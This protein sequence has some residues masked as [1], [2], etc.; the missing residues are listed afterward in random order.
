MIEA[1]ASGLK[2]AV[3]TAAAP[4]AVA[5]VGDLHN[6]Y[7]HGAAGNRQLLPEPLPAT[8]DTV[9]DLASLTKVVATTTAIMQCRD[10]GIIDLDDSVGGHLA[11]PAFNALTIRQLLTHTSG[12][13]PG[14]PFY[15][16]ATSMDEMLGMYAS[17]N[18]DRTPG[19]GRT[20]SDVGFMML[21][22][23]V[24]LATWNRLDEFCRKYIFD[25]LEMTST[26]FNP[27]PELALRAA[28]TENCTWRGRIMCGEVHDENAYA[29]GG[30]S[31]HAGLFSTAADLALFC[32]GLLDGSLF[33]ESTVDEMMQLGLL[34]WYPWQGLGWQ[35]DPWLNTSSGFLPSRGAFGHTGWTGTCL[36][37]DREINLIA[38]LLSNTCHPTRAGRHNA[39]LRETFYT[40]VAKVFYPR[41]ANTHLGIDRLV[42]DGFDE[43]AGKRIA[44]LTNHAAVDSLG[45]H[46]TDVL[47]LAPATRIARLYSPEH[48]IAG[49]AEAGEKVGS[50]SAAAP[51]TSLYGQQ[52]R[53]TQNELN[54]IDVFVIDLP[55]VG[56]RYYTYAATMK[57][58]LAACAEAGVRVLVL[59]RPNPLGG[60]VLEGP[61]AGQAGSPVCWGEVPVRH[62]M[63]MGEIARWFQAAAFAKSKLKL[64]ISA[65]DNW[66]RGNLYTECSLPWVPPSP[67]IPTPET[68]LLYVGMCLFEGTNLNEGRGTEIPFHVVGAPW[69]DARAVVGAIAAEDCPGCQLSPVQYTPVSIPGKAAN[70]RFQNQTCQGVR[71]DIKA[72]H[73]LR[74]FRTAVAL[75]NA[76]RHLHKSDFAWADSF[77]VLAGGPGLRQRIEAGT[78]AKD[79]VAGFESALT[80]YDKGRPKL[81]E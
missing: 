13:V 9:Y 80:A 71:I 52:K 44:V 51:V 38:I 33:K 79:I 45:R 69:L 17:M 5:Y 28:A 75:L 41:H 16:E 50:Q 19:T 54:T 22:R 2:N 4:G 8:T 81:Y 27:P 61:V 73:D 6:T 39:V 34:P 68:A 15:R 67:N 58:C 46:V 40:S 70:P 57:E 31:G 59:D 1:L 74:A 66:P 60:L 47:K 25:P 21:G 77:D 30:I 62:G 23:I 11:L 18:L 14:R 49:Q 32:R 78:P 55:D 43:I 12:L 37:V 42:L 26:T 48:G 76:I 7:F 63:T 56:A 10:S 36:W 65:L 35:L 3:Q 64:S 53:P 72:P 24:E 20:Y 29:V